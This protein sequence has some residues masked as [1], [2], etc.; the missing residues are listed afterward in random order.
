MLE[1]SRFKVCYYKNAFPKRSRFILV[2]FDYEYLPETS[3]TMLTQMLFSRSDTTKLTFQ[4]RSQAGDQREIFSTALNKL[5]G[6]IG[7]NIAC[8]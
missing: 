1:N 2:A 6:G 4:T 5:L 8:S 3:E 7:T